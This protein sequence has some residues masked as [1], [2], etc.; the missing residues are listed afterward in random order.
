MYG[1][2]GGKKFGN[3]GS[4]SEDN[5]IRAPHFIYGQEFEHLFGQDLDTLLMEK[6]SA[7]PY[8]D[9]TDGKIVN[10]PYYAQK[11]AR[12]SIGTEIPSMVPH[13]DNLQ[14]VLL[15]RRVSLI[16][17]VLNKIVKK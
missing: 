15:K 16:I 3:P 6:S 13:M 11:R 17:F 10:K 8:N 5:S 7:R 2:G 14:D 12:N 9:I 1:S 4:P